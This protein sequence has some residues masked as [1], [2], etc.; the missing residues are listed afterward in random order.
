MGVYAWMGPLVPE[1]RSLAEMVVYAIAVMMPATGF[2]GATFPLAVRILARDERDAAPSTARIY[3]WNTVGGIAGALLAGFWLLPAFGFGGSVKLAI[4][5]NGVLAIVCLLLVSRPRPVLA[6]A[7]ALA[8]LAV[9][10]L[11]QPGRPRAVLVPS[12][13]VPQRIAAL[14]EVF[15]AV[16]RSAT[17]LVVDNGES[18]WLLSNGLAEAAIASAGSP[19]ALEP[20]AWLTALAV[21]ARPD[22]ATL[23]LVGFGGGVA[24]GGLPASVRQVDVVELEPEVIRANRALQGLRA[25]DPLADERVRVVVNDARNALRLTSQRYDAIVSQPSHPWTAGASHLFTREFVR[26]ARSHLNEG[27]VFVQWMGAGFVTLPLLRSMAATLLAEFRDVRVYRPSRDDLLFLASDAPLDLELELVRSGRPLR[28]EP[29]HF[30]RLGISSVE[31]LVAALVTDH[32]GLERFAA[33]APII[34]DDRNRMATESHAVGGER[35]GAEPE[36]LAHLAPHDPLLDSKSWIHT[37]LRGDLNF[38]HL[39]RQLI[40]MGKAERARALAGRLE[41]GGARLLLLAELHAEAG[42]RARASRAARA[43]LESDPSDPQAGYFLFRLELEATGSAA[44][45]AGLLAGLEGSALA[46]ARGWQHARD[47]DWAALEALDSAL[48]QSRVT[49]VWYPDAALLRARWRCFAGRDRERLAAEALA[50]VDG[51]WLQARDFRLHL[52][53]LRIATLLGDEGVLVESARGVVG[54]FLSQ[55][56]GG[57]GADLPPAQ[58]A[59]LRQNLTW[60]VGT[61]EREFSADFR[62]RAHAV[63]AAA[64]E[65]LARLDGV[66]VPVRAPSPRPRPDTGPARPG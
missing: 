24:L 59:Q 47:Q 1:G 39:A 48:A 3:A 18:H 16:G 51:A 12:D 26:S 34:T 53:R 40:R 2:I 41:E 20:Q 50:L 46:V 28:D 19:P 65:L 14:H 23:L 10:L 4:C 60:V 30:R 63:R 64:H 9:L 52:E 17:V 54:L 49:D 35:A 42:D 55:L 27:G 58:R 11:Y 61:L 33:G 7:A 62:H 45:G 15:Y 31:D 44:P 36:V 5:T 43:A 22:L 25:H 13:V 6:G 56:A 21:A 57:D 37:R 38:P 29:D 66:P 8:V 32:A